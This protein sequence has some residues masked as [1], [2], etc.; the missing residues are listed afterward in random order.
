MNQVEFKIKHLTSSI[1]KLRTISSAPFS[2]VN[3]FFIFAMLGIK[4]KAL[5]K[6]GKYSTTELHT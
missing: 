3:L 6:L 2:K 4:S 5:S 1:T